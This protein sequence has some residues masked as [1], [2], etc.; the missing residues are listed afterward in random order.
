MTKYIVVT[1]EQAEQLQAAGVPVDIQYVVEIS[2]L[3]A[4]TAAPAVA[5]TPA[6]PVIKSKRSIRFH[7]D[8]VLR[9]TGLKWTGARNNTQGHMAYNLLAE[10]FAKRQTQTAIRRDLNAMLTKGMLAQGQAFSSSVIT[11]L[12]L[13]KYLEPVKRD[14]EGKKKATA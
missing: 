12:C 8:T 6:Q 13:Q 11:Y 14:T 4:K 1:E 10:Y 3:T 5:I 2:H 9:W 7:T